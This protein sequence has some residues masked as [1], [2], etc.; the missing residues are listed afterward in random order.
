LKNQQ[1]EAVELVLSQLI[2]KGIIGK[3]IGLHISP[4]RT[5]RDGARNKRKVGTF[6]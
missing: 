4:L 5:F 1:G 3:I 2:G 6:V